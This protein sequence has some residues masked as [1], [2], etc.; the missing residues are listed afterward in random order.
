MDHFTILTPDVEM[1]VAFYQDVI[2]FTLGTT[3]GPNRCSTDQDT[4]YCADQPRF[5]TKQGSFLRG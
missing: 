3:A 1:T 4:G 5:Q 2:G